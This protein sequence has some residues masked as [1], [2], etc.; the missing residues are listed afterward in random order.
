MTLLNSKL[1]PPVLDPD[2]KNTFLKDL[3]K[4]YSLCKIGKTESKHFECIYL[5]D[6][7]SSV[8]VSNHYENKTATCTITNKK[9]KDW[10]SLIIEK[11]LYKTI[12]SHYLQKN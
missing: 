12:L 8:C 11:E 7:V 10:E 3:Y 6:K 9:T 5:E 1:Y 4:K 2:D